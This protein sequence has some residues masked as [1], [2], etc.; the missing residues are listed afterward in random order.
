MGEIVY[1]RN[2][3]PGNSFSRNSISRRAARQSLIPLAGDRFRLHQRGTHGEMRLFV[4]EGAPGSLPVLAAA[5]R[6]QSRVELLISTVGPEGRRAGAGGRWVRRAGREHARH[7]LYSC[8]LPSPIP[9]PCTPVRFL[10][11]CPWAPHPVS[12]PV[13]S[14]IGYLILLSVPFPHLLPPLLRFPG[15]RLTSVKLFPFINLPHLP[16]TPPRP[17]T[18]SLVTHM[19]IPQ[20]PLSFVL[21]KPHSPLLNPDTHI[22]F[23]LPLLIPSHLFDS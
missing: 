12:L 1:F 6:A 4:S 17:H 23:G 16:G 18:H 22:P 7:P 11:Q 8:L 21:R 19:T 10:P 15:P 5:G 20:A 14:F 3:G 2:P 9:P 13:T